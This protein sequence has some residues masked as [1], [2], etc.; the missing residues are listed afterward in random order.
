MAKKEIIKMEKLL[1]LIIPTYNMEKLLNRCLSSLVVKDNSL[2]QQVEILVVIDGAKDR[3]SEIAHGYQ[4]RYP[5]VFRVIDK[6]NGNYGSCINRGLKEATGKY[7]KVLD[8]DDCFN[9]EAFTQYLIAIKNLDADL[10]ITSGT[11]VTE[12]DEPMLKWK[13]DYEPNQMYPI[14]ALKR[15]WIHEVTHKTALLREIGYVKTEGISYTD[16]EWVFYPMSTIK[17]FFT[18]NLNLY[19]YTVGREGQTM[20]PTV[21]SRSMKN[22]IQVSKGFFAY[23]ATHANLGRATS[24]YHSKMENRMQGFYYRALIE[25]GLYRNCELIAF[26]K[27][28]KNNQPQWYQRTDSYCTEDGKF[29]FIKQWRAHDYGITGI[30]YFKIYHWY[31]TIRDWKNKLMK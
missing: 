28:I 26:D 30:C 13:F 29:H 12:Q 22:E 20:N 24:F 1:T 18:L 16:E 7:I 2:F 3:S 4:N 17:T 6:E 9:T 31:L 11:N 8:A 19:Q 14:E 27:W 21:W 25:C 10:I 5:S 15:V 23:F